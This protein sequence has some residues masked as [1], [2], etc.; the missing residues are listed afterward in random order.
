MLIRAYKK[1]KIHTD[2]TQKK[3]IFQ[4]IIAKAKR[5]CRDLNQI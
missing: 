5:K 1:E 2:Y 3:D 4:N